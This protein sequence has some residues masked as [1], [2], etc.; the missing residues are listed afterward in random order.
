MADLLA[1]KKSV[2]HFIN[3]QADFMAQKANVTQIDDTDAG[4]ETCS[5]TGSE[6]GTETGSE[7]GPED[8]S[9]T[10]AVDES[11]YGSVTSSETCR[12]DS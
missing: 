3:D 5:K 8:G 11:D 10:G 6:I 1:I 12:F 9:E 2:M 7:T 4:S